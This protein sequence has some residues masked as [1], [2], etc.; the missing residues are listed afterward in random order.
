LALA[1]SAQ[2]EGEKAIAA[3]DYKTAEQ[4]FIRANVLISTI[5]Q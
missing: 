4:D 2:F 1:Q 3:G 5:N